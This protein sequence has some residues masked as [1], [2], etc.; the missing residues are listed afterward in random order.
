M[1][2]QQSHLYMYNNGVNSIFMMNRDV[3]SLN[4]DEDNVL[5]L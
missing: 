1:Q 5:H 2:K 4:C 3:D